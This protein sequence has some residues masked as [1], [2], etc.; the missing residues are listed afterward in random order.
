MK[1]ENIYLDMVKDVRFDISSYE[2]DRLLPE[3]KNKKVNGKNEKICSIKSKKYI[4]LTDKSNEKAKDTKKCVVNRKRK[5][6]DYLK[7][8]FG[9]NST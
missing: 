1:T 6:E 2:S 3:G 5:F 4:H 7:T 9:S 8:L